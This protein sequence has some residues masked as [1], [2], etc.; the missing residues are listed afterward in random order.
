MAEGEREREA[1]DI[2]EVRAHS[3]ELKRELRLGDLVLTQVMFVVG[4]GWVGTAAKLGHAQVVYWL[5]AVAL[6]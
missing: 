1:A 4:S 5:L 2:G 3:A 6:F